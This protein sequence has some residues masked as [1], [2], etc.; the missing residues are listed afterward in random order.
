MT[1]APGGTAGLTA[2]L[3]FFFV[4]GAAM[5]LF[6]WHTLSD[7]LAGLPV[8]GGRFLLAIALAGV[9]AGFACLLARYLESIFGLPSEGEERE[10]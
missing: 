8:E 7:F 3:A 5:A 4:V 6:I 10:H 9:F 2:V 1:K